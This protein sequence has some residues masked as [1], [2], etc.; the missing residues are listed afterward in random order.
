MPDNL[1]I[2]GFSARAAAASAVR[3]GFSPLA[4]D[5]FADQDLQ[6]VGA[7]RGVDCYP[8]DLVSAARDMPAAPFLYTGALENHPEVVNQIQRTRLLLG[9]G[10]AVIQQVRDPVRLANVC[11]DA[12]SP[13]PPMTRDSA[14]VPLDGNW[15]RKRERSSG[16]GSVQVW[17]GGRREGHRGDYF[18]QRLEGLSCSAVFVAVSGTAILLGTTEQLVGAGWAG[19]RRFNYSGSIGPLNLN[20]TIRAAWQ[21]IGGALADEFNLQGLFNVDAILQGDR[22]S[23]LEVNPRYSASIEVLER[24]LGIAAVTLHVEACQ[25]QRFSSTF[26]VPPQRICGKAV[27]YAQRDVTIDARFPRFV[28]QQNRALDWPTIADIPRVGTFIRRGRPLCTVLAE[29][30][31]PG[32]V[33]S[34]LQRLA[35]TIQGF[36]DVPAPV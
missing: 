1:L 21:Q 5:F 12:G 30:P 17:Y 28:L 31:D 14:N 11:S 4:L 35:A 27:C 36:F 26:D 16:G 23:P 6:T 13:M 7:A 9:N 22:L 10:P 34:A 25:G 3:A 2:V 15:L 20:S 32:A 18:Q 33:E 24:A 8:D 29:G 19:A